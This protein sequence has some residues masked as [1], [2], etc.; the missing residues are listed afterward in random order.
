MSAVSRSELKTYFVSGASPTEEQF[1]NLIDSSVNVTEDITDSHALED[2]AK[3]L[4]AAG[5]KLL[6]DLV[7]GIDSRVVL[8]EN[9]GPSEAPHNYYNKDEVD[10][11]VS[12][13]GSTIDNLPYAT[14]IS[15]LTDRVSAN[16]TGLL[17]KA[18]S[19]HNHGMGEISGL[20]SALDAKLDLSAWTTERAELNTAINSKASASHTHVMADI[21]DLAEF[22]LSLY[23]RL[24]DLETK[25][26]ASHTHVIAEI[27]DIGTV[28]Y[29]KTEVDTKIDE[30]SGSHTH[31]EADI[32]DLDKYTQSQTNLKILDHSNLTDNPHGVTKEQVG[33][34]NVENISSEEIFTTQASVDYKDGII[35]E[36]QGTIDNTNTDISSHIVDLANPH[37]VTKEQVGLGVVPNIDVKALLDAHLTEDN[38]H[39]IDLSYFD[40]YSKAETDERVTLGLDSIRYAFV[41]TSPTDSAGSVGDLTWGADGDG[42]YKAYLKVSDANWRAM[43]LFAEGSDGNVIFDYDV[44]FKENIDVTGCADISEIKICNN[45]IYVTTTDSDLIIGTDSV[46]QNVEIKGNL[47][48]QGTQTILNTATLDVEDKFITLNKNFTGDPLESAAGNSG[49][50]VERGNATNAQ[51]YWDEAS[52]TWKANLGGT[53][54][55]IMF[56]EDAYSNP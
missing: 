20:G 29:N 40:V 23:A 27:S 53:I 38:P 46:A 22:D 33:L 41:P 54:K 18:D 11:K 2:S 49:I 5:A 51:I 37:Q 16:E 17:G 42:N 52:D 13:L 4:S 3:V 15:S 34:G 8:L 24:I 31:L 50:D 48:V 55:T 12:S 14:Q 25:A 1:A 47:T 6:R 7:D 21:L 56:S 19:S 32:T 28:Y 26:D 30:V 10:E 39:D 35:A 44:E 36:V 9:V 45:N 43:N